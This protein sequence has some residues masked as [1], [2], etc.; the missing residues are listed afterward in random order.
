[1]GGEMWL[2]GEPFLAL[3]AGGCSDGK[4]SDPCLGIGNMRGNGGMWGLDHAG[5]GNMEGLAVSLVGCDAC[6]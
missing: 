6:G 1:M 5:C 3:A 4:L 2:V